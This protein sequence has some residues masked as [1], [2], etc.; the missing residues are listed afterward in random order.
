LSQIETNS[1]WH[2]IELSSAVEIEAAHN[3]PR[4]MLSTALLLSSFDHDARSSHW[5]IIITSGTNNSLP[6][7][8]HQ[9][10][11]HCC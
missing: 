3:L 5:S 8:L 10:V 11:M 4:T 1:I 7:R 6:E 2:G 9:L